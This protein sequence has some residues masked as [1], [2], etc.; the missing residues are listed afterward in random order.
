MTQLVSADR[1]K[2]GTLI[3]VPHERPDAGRLKRTGRRLDIH[4]QP[5]VRR[6]ANP[7]VG[8]ERLADVNRERQPPALVG[9][10]VN[11]DLT[12]PPVDIGQLKPRDLDRA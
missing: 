9:L 2:A 11:L 7:E 4:E 10:A 8:H 1:V 3:G 6:A 5:L 12:G